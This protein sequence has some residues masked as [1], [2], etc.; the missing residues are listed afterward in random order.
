MKIFQ[1]M[2]LVV[3]AATT[4]CSSEIPDAKNEKKSSNV[5]TADNEGVVTAE[6]DANAKSD[7]TVVASP[8]SKV[9]EASVTFPPGSV[10]LSTSMAFGEA[11]DA[12]AAVVAELGLESAVVKSAAPVF[13]GPSSGTAAATAGTIG[14]SLP[15]PLSDL[16]LGLGLTNAAGKL[17]FLYA[18]YSSEGW[19]SGVKPLT[20]ADLVGTFLR[21]DILGFGYFQ[22][23]YLAGSV[24]AKEVV[25]Q[26]RPTLKK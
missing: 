21:A 8:N 4:G 15:L 13:L 23:A 24:D 2:L 22:I 11:T 16:G 1:Y 19:K 6:I 3:A 7:Q 20:A 14:L 26:I 10:A 5:A 12:S 25:S 9:A 18:Y 17:V